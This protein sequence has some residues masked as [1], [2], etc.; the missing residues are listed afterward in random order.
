MMLNII[1]FAIATILIALFG[2]KLTTVA[3]RLA[4]RTGLGEAITGG[5]LLGATTSMAGITAS[6][7][8][9]IADH[10][11]IALSNAL[12]GIAAQ[13]CFLAIADLC[14][15]KA[16]LEHAAASVPN[17]MQGALLI[18]LL[19]L[20]MLASIGPDISFGGIHII[21]PILLITYLFGMRM[22]RQTQTR[23]MWRPRI[24]R[25]TREDHPDEEDARSASL[26][27]LVLWFVFAAIVVVSSGWMLTRAVVDMAEQTGLSETI[28]G[29]VLTA[30]STS[31]PELV[32]SIAA[33]RR[34]AL[35]MAVGGVIG[36]NAFDTLFAAVADVAYLDGS[37]YHNA[38]PHEAW[39]VGLTILMTAVLLL[40]LLRRQ[41]L[42]F[43]G[44]G[45]ES[46]LVFVLYVLGMA[47]I[48]V[49]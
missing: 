22:V 8:A 12:G 21:T 32:T 38:T 46:V 18:V 27:R 11:A 10:P 36:G 20:V 17:M 28:A 29:G 4:D 15:R 42:G 13:T 33:V 26:P 14:Y 40:G 44:I 23:P 16:N 30:I 7:T 45:F 48:G 41:E 1:I 25:Q 31:I 3:D 34:G 5:L 19:A 47:A 2:T 43:A 49:G 39:L 6:V 24:T 9:A 35:T 37:I